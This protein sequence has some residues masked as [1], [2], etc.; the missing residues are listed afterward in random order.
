MLQQ[1]RARV[2]PDSCTRLASQPVWWETPYQHFS[3]RQDTE[4]TAMA[5]AQVA[6][7]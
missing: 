7:G 3:S 2:P 4:L 1:E 5:S 6:L